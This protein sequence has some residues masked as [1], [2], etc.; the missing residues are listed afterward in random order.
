MS[1]HLPPG[2]TQRQ[3]DDAH[4]GNEPEHM[5]EAELIADY[6]DHLQRT[7]ESAD[8][9]RRIVV[10]ELRLRRLQEDGK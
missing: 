8:D 7:A 2:V 9:W 3:I 4:Q 5:T 10:L 1:G 6:I